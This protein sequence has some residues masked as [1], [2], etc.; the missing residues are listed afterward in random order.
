MRR[1][2]DET[3]ASRFV[4]ALRAALSDD[5]AAA[6][7]D[8]DLDVI[9]RWRR[10]HR[11]FDEDIRRAKADVALLNAGRVRLAARTDW[12]AALALAERAEQQRELDRLRALTTDA[13]P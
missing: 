2:F 10:T 3:I 7:V 4:D 13:R 6:H 8:V 5:D 1:K 11:R 12:R 9:E